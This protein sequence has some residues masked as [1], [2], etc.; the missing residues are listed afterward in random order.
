MDTPL[1]LAA[2]NGYGTVFDT[3]IQYSSDWTVG[4][5][6]EHTLLKAAWYAP[7][8]SPIFDFLLRSH[9]TKHLDTTMQME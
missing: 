1:T 9:I 7:E 4:V 3:L 8:K 5:G 6:L 2:K